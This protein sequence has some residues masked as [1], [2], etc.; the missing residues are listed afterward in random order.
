MA[1]LEV[2]VFEERFDPASKAW[3]L[4]L[5]PLASAQSQDIQLEDPSSPELEREF[6]WY[7]EDF[8]LQDPFEKSRALAAEQSLLKYAE[9]IRDAI[10]EPLADILRN[11]QSTL[12][13]VT[14]HL[15]IKSEGSNSSLQRLHWEL[16]ENLEL[17]TRLPSTCKAIQVFRRIM[18]AASSPITECPTVTSR[19]NVLVTTARPDL[20]EDIPYRL[21]SKNIW[22][23]LQTASHLGQHINI[24]IVRPG[25]WEALSKELNEKD[26]GYYHLI[27]FDTHGVVDRTTR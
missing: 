16:L 6:L 13:E 8:A 25:T 18:S 11:R 21:V 14:V 9:T 3:A 5:T 27:H 4:S 24:K 10:E 1:V 12:Q 22:K 26:K 23:T 20:D 2:Q 7:W 19:L 17:W 15:A